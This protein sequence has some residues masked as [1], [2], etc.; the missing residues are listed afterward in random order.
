MQSIQ[1]V[2]SPTSTVLAGMFSISDLQPNLAGHLLGAVHG[3][4]LVQALRVGLLYGSLLLHE[5]L[6]VIQ[7]VQLGLV[8][9]LEIVEMFLKLP[10]YLFIFNNIK[11]SYSFN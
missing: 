9:A 2:L 10:F 6:D 3:G 7:Q 11:K 8:L 1:S 4:Q 5:V